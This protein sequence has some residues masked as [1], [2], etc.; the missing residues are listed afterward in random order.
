VPTLVVHGPD[1]PFAD[2]QDSRALADRHPDLIA[3]H[4]VPGAP[5]AAMWNADPE[6]YEEALRRF[7]TPLM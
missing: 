4:A 7:L 2:W 3:F 1:D 5:H 6:G